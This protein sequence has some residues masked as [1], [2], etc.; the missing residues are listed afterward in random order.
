MPSYCLLMICRL[1]T[2]ML[3]MMG[4]CCSPLSKLLSKKGAEFYETKTVHPNRQADIN[5]S[6]AALTFYFMP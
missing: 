2:R 5:G 3:S 1:Y 6:A 4:A